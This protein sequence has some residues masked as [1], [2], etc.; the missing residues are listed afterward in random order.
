MLVSGRLSSQSDFSQPEGCLIKGENS[1][2]TGGAINT[3]TSRSHDDW[4]R[5]SKLQIWF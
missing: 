2:N 5:L 1:G 4:Q 3:V